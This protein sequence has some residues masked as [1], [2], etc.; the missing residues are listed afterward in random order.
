MSRHKEIMSLHK[1]AITCKLRQFFIVTQICDA[2]VE[3]CRDIE[4]SRRNIFS[5]VHVYFLS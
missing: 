1:F 5:D 4:K 3:N 2:L